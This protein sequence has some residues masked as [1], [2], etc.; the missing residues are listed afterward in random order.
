MAPVCAR[1]TEGMT[2]SASVGVR[3]GA[4]GVF[5]LAPAWDDITRGQFADAHTVG[6][7]APRDDA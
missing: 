4:R 6:G 1:A 5:G 2:T 3:L 7:P